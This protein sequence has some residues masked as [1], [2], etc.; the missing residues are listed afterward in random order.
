VVNRNPSE[1]IPP[2]PPRRIWIVMLTRAFLLS[3]L[4]ASPLLA[5]PVELQKRGNL[6]QGQWDSES[7][8][9]GMYT[10]YN[11]LWG[12]S[13][14]TSGSQTTQETSASGTSVAWETT[15]NWAGGSS[16]VKSY[17]NLGLNTNLGKPL[18]AISSIPS[19]WQWTYTAA[20][21]V[22]A[23]VSYDL[24]LSNSATPGTANSAS[25]YEVMIWLSARGGAGPVGGQVATANVAGTSWALHQGT[26]E[27][28]T[29]FS[30]V[31]PEEITSFSADL[32]DFFDY[33]VQ[34]FG[35]ST[36][37]FFSGGG[38]GTEPFTGSATLTT[39]SLSMQVM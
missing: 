5:S 13:A 14:A 16:S 33:L 29:V 4:F 32:L 25:T 3:A 10:L 18:S 38:A 22:V 7:E 12:E 19:T 21:N 35:V 37:N 24:W 1:H 28:W 26:V 9:S 6:L 17:A 31:A 8:L 36:S 23:D 15:W 34:N 27:N 39:T 11:N 30:F 2:P 20:E